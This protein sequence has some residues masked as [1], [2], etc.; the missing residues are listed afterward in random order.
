VT[1]NTKQIEALSALPTM[2]KE[3]AAAMKSLMDAVQSLT[4]LSPGDSFEDDAIV[5]ISSHSDPVD[6]LFDSIV[7]TTSNKG[8]KNMIKSYLSFYRSLRTIC[9]LV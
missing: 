6:N 3:Q 1:E 7:G 4:E 8:R 2:M 9:E 5:D